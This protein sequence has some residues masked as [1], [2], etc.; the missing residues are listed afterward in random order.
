MKPLILWGSR[1]AWLFVFCAAACGGQREARPQVF[2][3][4]GATGGAGGS[5]T[6]DG[7][8]AG[9]INVGGGHIE[10]PPLDSGVVVFD[11]ATGDEERIA[12]CGDGLINR[13]GEVCDDGNAVGGDGC[14]AECDQV[15]ANFVC[16]TPGRPC[17]TTARCGDGVVSGLETCDDG[18]SALS[19]APA[20]GDG[21]DASCHIEDGFTCPL[22]GAACR[23]ICGD[24]K[25]RGREQCDD[26]MDPTTGAPAA[27]DGCDT[28]CRVEPGWV[29]PAGAACRRTVCGDGN[30]EGSE[31]CDDA[32]LRPYDGCSPTCTLEPQCGTATSPAG[33]CASH[34]GDG[35][36][37]ASDNE[38]CD[39]GN[40][41]AGDGCGPDCRIEPGFGCTTLA[42]MPPD[43]IDLP[44]VLRDFKSGVGRHPDF[45]NLCCGVQPGIV[46]PLLG[47]DRKPIYA[48]TDLMP[49]NLTTGATN[50]N[51]WYNDHDGTSL[52]GINL[53]FDKT[54]RLTRQSDG[55]YS[56]NS[57]TEPQWV[58]LNGFFPLDPINGQPQG[59]GNEFL[60]HNFSF[61]SEV[62]YWFEYRG[63]ERLD[64][65]GDDDVFVF[66]NGTLAVDLGGVHDRLFG[67]VVLDAAGHGRSCSAFAA[68]CVPAGDIDFGM[69][70]GDIY[71]AVVFQAERHPSASNYWLTLTNFLPKKS[72]CL[73]VCGD[74]VVT[75]DEACDLGRAN[76]TGAHGGCNPD[77]T[78]A[79]FCGDGV[80]QAADGEACDD[81]VN[82]SLYGG[83]AP[84]CVRGPSCGDG[85]VQAPYEQC[86]DGVNDGGYR[87]CAP[88]C[89]YD[90]RCGDGVVQAAYEQCDEGQ[91]NGSGRCRIDCT[92]G[93]VK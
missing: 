67:T 77:C 66:L 5:A 7:G 73:P 53:R 52:T 75:P 89:R 92:L 79:P 44:L 27:G 3:R 22:P 18:V 35:I 82:T 13:A 76:N 90:E 37:L 65:S 41:I 28:N 26:G 33:R 62:R 58:A 74:G 70:I 85:L 2:G 36:L 8:I 10:P 23:P 60:D 15:E 14:T 50:F 21:C 19:G 12:F 32:K 91:A 45:N 80:V 39:D 11:A 43:F 63:G 30:V 55:S 83:C 24:G 72:L 40:K 47:L 25:V 84:G 56:M 4:G 16:P 1:A 17:V 87:E 42:E 64:F 6:P 38:Q 57:A 93:I 46:R 54:L 20:A 61:T 71:E 81:G 68:G 29:C 78:L 51:D 86:D 69:Q 49:I 59:W 9:G 31:Q 88:G 34:C 48:G